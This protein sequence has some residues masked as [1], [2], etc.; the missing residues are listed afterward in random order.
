MNNS[1]IVTLIVSIFACVFLAATSAAQPSALVRPLPQLAQAASQVDVAPGNL[2]LEITYYKD[3]PPAYM[4]LG[5]KA[6]YARFRRTSSWQTP[7]GSLPVK[8]VNIVS[9]VEGNAV[10]VR[11]SVYDGARFDDKEEFVGEYVVRENE[12]ITVRELTRFGVEPFEIG[13]VHVAPANPG[14]PL[15]ENKTSSITVLALEANNTTLP[16]FKLSL[17]NLSNKNISALAIRTLVDG[18]TQ[19]SSLP[20]DPE[21]RPLM[22]AGESYAT[23]EPGAHAAHRA[24]EGY[25]PDPPPAQTIVIATAVF[26]DGSYEGEAAPAA[27]YRAFAKGRKTQLARIIPL[28]QN[29][30]DAPASNAATAIEKLNT[31]LSTLNEEMES[32]ALEELQ[33]EFPE[34]DSKAKAGLGNAVQIAIYGIRKRAL[35]DLNKFAT[36][37]AQAA[38]DEAFRAWLSMTKVR[39][40]AWLA[41]L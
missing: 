18:K 25:M 23:N 39:Y 28:L 26:D 21:A 24:P 19:I 34:F 9:R 2:A 17:R 27:E 20:H 11:V 3:L 35:D 5:G 41:R 36:A 8:A 29:A 7:T 4:R 15:V 6:W 31:Q 38:D 13:L 12:K 1:R 22:K 16:S 37:T 10:K 14:L 30:L 32:S 33:K 40:A